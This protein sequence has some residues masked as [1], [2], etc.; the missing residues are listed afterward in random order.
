MREF[1]FRAYDKEKGKM[2][3]ADNVNCGD[4]Y[5]FNCGHKGLICK[6]EI[7]YCDTFGEEHVS[8][9]DLDNLM[10]YTESKDKNGK[11]IYEGD[12]YEC[13]EKRIKEV[14]WKDNGF[15][16]K[17]TYERTYCGEKY[18]ETNYL[19]MGPTSD[20]RWGGKVIGNIFENPEL[21]MGRNK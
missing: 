6:R 2:I 21:L 9:E 10:Q 7:N 18:T 16:M 8:Y 12:I 13:C 4:N 19:E 3:Y 20:E 14:V 17:Y 15:K 5:W 1:K 11:E